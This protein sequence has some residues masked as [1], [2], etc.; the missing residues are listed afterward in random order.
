[1][2]VHLFPSPIQK[3]K[4]E[5]TWKSGSAPPIR[6]HG[7]WVFLTILFR[8]DSR[9]GNYRTSSRPSSS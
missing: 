9:S 8:T 6:G 7:E 1:M 4:I 2:M 3:K 5:I